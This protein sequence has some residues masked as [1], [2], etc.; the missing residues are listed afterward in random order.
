MRI[1]IM[2]SRDLDTM[3]EVEFGPWFGPSVKSA[4]DKQTTG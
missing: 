3:K 2:I 4:P 1:R